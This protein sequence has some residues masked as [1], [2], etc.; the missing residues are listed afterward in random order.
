M[1]SPEYSV[2]FRVSLHNNQLGL[3]LTGESSALKVAVEKKRKEHVDIRECDCNMV[4]S[5][6]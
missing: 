6:L 3:G 5:Y 2:E 1:K 4:K